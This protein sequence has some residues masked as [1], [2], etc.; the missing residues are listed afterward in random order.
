MVGCRRAVADEHGYFLA[1]LGVTKV[2][3]FYMGDPRK[4]C[5]VRLR[6]SPD[7]ECNN[8]T[9]INYSS[10]EG[11]PLRDE[12]KRWAD[13]DYDNVVYATGPLAFR[14]CLQIST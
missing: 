13:H 8:P 7:F 6:A 4:A 10:I 1:E 12:G 2:S 3:D 9:T 5:Y 14:P 11:A